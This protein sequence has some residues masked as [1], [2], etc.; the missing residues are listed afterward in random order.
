MSLVWWP[1][2][3]QALQMLHHVLHMLL[4]NIQDYDHSPNSC[5]IF[6]KHIEVCSSVLV[7]FHHHLGGGAKYISCLPVY[8]KLDTKLVKCCRARLLLTFK[9]NDSSW[10][11]LKMCYIRLTTIRIFLALLRSD[12]TSFSIGV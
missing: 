2:N 11:T 7:V 5:T 8:N 12:L 4:T 3:F 1:L 6:P 9:C 10:V